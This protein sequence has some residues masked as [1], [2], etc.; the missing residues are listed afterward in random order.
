MS[1]LRIAAVLA[2]CGLAGCGSVPTSVTALTA[3]QLAEPA[4]GTVV[5]ST[6]AAE[7]CTALGMWA[8]IYDAATHKLAAGTPVVPIDE[9]SDSDYPDHYGTLSALSLPPGRYLMTVEATNPGYADIET[10]SFAFEV[11]AGRTLYLGDLVRV[12]ACAKASRYV[13]AD[14]YDVDV[15]LAIKRNPALA[16]RSPERA[17]MTFAHPTAAR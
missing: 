16:A 3:A 12:N 2:A 8:P 14:H 6:S 4:R 15:A 10:P 1:L 9:H 17:L 7:R 13:V 11:L 5:L